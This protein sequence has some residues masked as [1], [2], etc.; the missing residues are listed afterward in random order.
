MTTKD[1]R[2]EESADETVFVYPA[3][4]GGEIPADEAFLE[5]DVV[6]PGEGYANSEFEPQDFDFSVFDDEVDSLDDD[7]LTDDDRW[8][9]L[10]RAFGVEK[11]T[12]TE[13]ALC[14]VAI[15]GRPNVGKSSLV[16]RFLGRREAVVEDTPGV[17][18][19]RVSYLAEWNGRRFWV[20]DT[21][22]WDPD[23]KG[24]NAA[25][26][27]QAEVAMETADVIVMVVD[28]NVG[29]TASD[30]VM[31]RNLQRSDVPVILVA[32]KVDSPKQEAETAEFWGLGLDYPYPVSAQHGKGGADVLDQI[33]ELFPDEPRHTSITDG[34][35][36]VALV[37]KPNVGKS[38]LLNKLSKEERAVVDNVAGTTVDP[39]DSLVQLD[40]GLWKFIDTAGLRRK[41]KNASG[42]E[43][44]ASLRTQTAIDAAEVCILIIDAS[45]PVS[46]QDQKLLGMIVDAGKALILAF[47]KW[48]LVDE[49]RRDY[50]EREIDEQLRHVPW[51]KRV[52]ISAKTGRSLQKLEPVMLE[53]LESWDKRILS[54]IH[55]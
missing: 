51:A 18:R 54:L 41:V 5:E 55:I 43:Y 30:E 17:T 21:G 38:S 16:N 31:A 12:H 11:Q 34:P 26:A 49:D 13:E 4:D 22:G 28:T 19:D 25:I 39:V 47:N 6:A 36:R 23:A 33:L 37:G 50:L 2:P 7:E 1:Y 29:I 10:E 14:T 8:A 27:R 53:A 40:Q 46:E 9:E 48:D 24:M 44:Y 42:H 45:E 15:V 20:Q 3:N 35:R 52:N 32:N